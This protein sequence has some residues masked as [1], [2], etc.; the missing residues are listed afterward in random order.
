MYFLHLHFQCYPKSPPYPPTPLPTHSHFLKLIFR[1]WWWW[2]RWQRRWQRWWQCWCCFGRQ[3][4]KSLEHISEWNNVPFCNI[5]DLPQKE[6]IHITNRAATLKSQAS[7]AQHLG[8]GNSRFLIFFF[9]LPIKWVQG[10]PQAQET[11][12][13]SVCYLRGEKKILRNLKAWSES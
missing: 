7:I 10:L 13:S 9:F 12:G 11:Y 8:G 1:G 6:L 3:L 4:S 2:W 5:S